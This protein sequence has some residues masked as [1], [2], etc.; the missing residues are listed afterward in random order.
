MARTIVIAPRRSIAL[1]A[2][3][4]MAM[5]IA[6]YVFVILL[7]AACVYAPYSI[8][9]YAASA[10]VQPVL[11]LIGGIVVA[12]AMLLSL[13]PRRDHFEAPG[14]LLQRESHPRLFAELDSIAF[15][16]DEAL[17]VEVYLIAEPN[18][19]VGDR[20]GILGFG[21][22][23][24]MAIGL[25]L[26]S[27]LNISE[28]R[29]VLAHEFAHYYSGETKLGPFVYKAQI[30]LIRA[31]TNIGSMQEAVRVH[32]IR[33]LYLL[34]TFILQRYFWVFLRVTN[35]VSR[36]KEYR[37]DELACL[38]AGVSPFVHGL[39]KIHGA[40][41]PWLLYWGTELVPLMNQNCVPPV[42]DGFAQFLAVPY[43]AALANQNIEDEIAEGKVGQF[44]THPPLRDRIAAMESLTVAPT[45][46]NPALSISLLDNPSS[47]EVPLLTFAN[48]K[49]DL[50]SLRRIAWEDIG[51]QVT[52]STWKSIVNEN[53]SV[54]RGNKVSAVPSLTE[55]LSRIG[56]HIPDPK[57]MLLTPL[58]RSQRAIQLIASAIA[59]V[60]L[61]N[62][63]QL[64]FK[65]GIFYLHRATE[66]VD[67]FVMVRELVEG[68][69]SPEA[70]IDSCTKMGIGDS[71]LVPAATLT[72]AG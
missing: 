60:L 47:V 28:F 3:L 71:M 26:L 35:F 62:G 52:I 37:A 24:I 19:F 55:N 49:L 56:S 65:P 48:P 32:V 72:A 68:K 17:P 11:L 14:P 45:T 13:N 46:E 69:M 30:A 42:A 39:R 5:V 58:E 40:E 59:L 22:R 25:P 67:A 4:T 63:W 34:V 43:V 41:M 9:G 61:D 1:Y 64:E 21:S 51:E 66:T 29:A 2:L 6:S 20:G 70:W 57:G 18:A 27:L 16:L 7:A 8:L 38:V 33:V 44:D 31:V 23:R 50:N 36:K 12:A 15:A 53:G 54:L 10:I